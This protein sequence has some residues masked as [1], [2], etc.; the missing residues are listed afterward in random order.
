MQDTEEGGTTLQYVSRRCACHEP[1]WPTE[2]IKEGHIRRSKH[3]NLLWILDLR[4]CTQISNTQSM[5][6]ESSQS[7]FQLPTR[8]VADDPASG[9]HYQPQDSKH[10][11]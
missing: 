6:R 3:G 1:V 5:R 4:S 7:P 2:C 10:H 8:Q 11:H 9:D